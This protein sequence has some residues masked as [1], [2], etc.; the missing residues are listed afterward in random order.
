MKQVNRL[1]NDAFIDEEYSTVETSA[2]AVSFITYLYVNLV[3]S[4][5]QFVVLVSVMLV[6]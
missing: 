1:R 3:K 4:K 5:L 2:P 6:S